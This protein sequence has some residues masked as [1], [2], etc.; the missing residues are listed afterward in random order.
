MEGREGDAGSAGGRRE[1]EKGTHHANLVW[2]TRELAQV[3][4]LPPRL[5][6]LRIE[7]VPLLDQDVP[8]LMQ[9]LEL[10]LPQLIR[11]PRPSYTPQP[12]PKLH[13]KE[14]THPSYPSS[15]PAPPS[16]LPH[17]RTATTGG[18]SCPFPRAWASRL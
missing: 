5:L 9:L 4:P 15:D 12:S 11:R 18:P 14:R 8:Q 17:E 7:D 3:Q 10:L 6:P 13:K 2:H 16:S 1:E